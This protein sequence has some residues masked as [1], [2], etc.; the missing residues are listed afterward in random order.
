M[1]LYNAQSIISSKWRGKKVYYVVN[2]HLSF[3]SEW[4]PFADDDN[5]YDSPKFAS[6]LNM[7]KDDGQIPVEN[8]YPFQI[9]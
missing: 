9:H 1:M 8:S 2:L 7:L 3:H 5:L 4:V 6:C